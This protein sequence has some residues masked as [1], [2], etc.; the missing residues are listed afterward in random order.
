MGDRNIFASILLTPRGPAMPNFSFIIV[1]E[2]GG[3]ITRSESVGE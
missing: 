2:G 3:T 1:G